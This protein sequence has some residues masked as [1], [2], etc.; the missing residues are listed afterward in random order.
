MIRV[1]FLDVVLVFLNYLLNRRMERMSPVNVE[2]ALHPDSHFHP[3]QDSIISAST[4]KRTVTLIVPSMLAVM[5]VFAGTDENIVR[6]YLFLNFSVY[7][8]TNCLKLTTSRP[9]PYAKDAEERGFKWNQ[10]FESRKSFPSG[11][12][13]N[14]LISGIVAARY[15][16]RALRLTG[17]M[18]LLVQAPI[19]AFAAVPGLTQ[20]MCHWHHKTDV[21]AGYAL[22]LAYY[23]AY[24]SI[25]SSW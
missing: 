23:S 9:R 16:A 15:F 1:R 22:A 8:L 2:K 7:T 5:E 12:A 20:A 19:L 6:D 13:C 10:Y 17:L 3:Y 25:L 14:G 4:L 24:H 11:H 21:A 18:S